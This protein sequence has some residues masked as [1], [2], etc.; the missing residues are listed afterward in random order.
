MNAVDHEAQA[1]DRETEVAVSRGDQ[2]T[3]EY[4]ASLQARASRLVADHEAGLVPDYEFALHEHRRIE[5]ERFEAAVG[6]ES[7]KG[8]R[9]ALLILLVALVAAILVGMATQQFWLTLVVFSIGAFAARSP[10]RDPLD[11]DAVKAQ[12]NQLY[13]DQLRA[14]IAEWQ[15]RLDQER[16]AEEQAAAAAAW[17]A[18]QHRRAE[19]A[20]AQ[21]A[22]REAE[23]ELEALLAPARHSLRNWQLLHPHPAAQPYGVSPAGAEVWVRDW[24]I[25]MGAEGA[26][27]TQ[28]VGDGGI[29]VANPFF[30]AQ[31]KH[32]ANSVGVG[33][34][35]E[36]IGVAAVD[37]T[38]RR[39]LFFTSGTYSAGGLDAA[40]RAQ[41]PLFTYSVERAEVTPANAHAELILAIGLNPAWSAVER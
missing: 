9:R 11:I 40:E 29:D 28:Y 22:I 6:S 35:R 1:V 37:E 23:E 27:A 15:T 26:Q 16:Q 8:I 39:P 24:M 2:L 18:E 34:V 4:F 33:E 7:W 41:M 19:E 12:G 20:A 17:H 21:R 30:I 14:G 5:T 32:Y 13:I 25:H 38:K 10:L 31:V 3:E 36:H